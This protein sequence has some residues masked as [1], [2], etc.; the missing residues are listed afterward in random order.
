MLY[1]KPYFTG[2]SR[3]IYSSTRDF[4]ARVDRQQSLF[5]FSA[6]SIKVIGGW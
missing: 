2:K 4:L 6:G 3:E 5:M 1:E